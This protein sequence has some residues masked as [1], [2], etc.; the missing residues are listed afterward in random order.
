MVATCSSCFEAYLE[1]LDELLAFIVPYVDVAVI[2]RDEHPLLGGVQVTRLH[3]V[4][5]GQAG[6]VLGA[7][8]ASR[9]P[10]GKPSF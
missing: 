2:E 9:W 10:I 4:R 6:Q 5:P 8:K 7:A 1:G 3:T